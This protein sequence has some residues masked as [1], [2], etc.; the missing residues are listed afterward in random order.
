MDPEQ[1]AGIGIDLP[2]GFD[3]HTPAQ[4]RAWVQGQIEG[5]AVELLTDLG[6]MRDAV[7]TP[8][9]AAAFLRGIQPGIGRAL[10]G[11]DG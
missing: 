2:E 6:S 1:L 3:G 7:P 5:I 10:G 8:E 4:R 9:Q 11:I